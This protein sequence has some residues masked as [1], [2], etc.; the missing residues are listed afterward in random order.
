MISMNDTITKPM[1]YGRLAEVLESLGFVRRDTS[2]FTAFYKAE[3]D[4]IIGLPVLSPDEK[5]R[6]HHLLGI[7]ADIVGKRIATAKRFAQLLTREPATAHANGTNGNG[8]H[9]AANGIT[10]PRKVV[11]I[12]NG[13]RVGK[14]H[15]VLT[16][17]AKRG[18][19]D[20]D[21]N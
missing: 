7:Q 6:S 14:K 19:T 3:C 18:Q 4:A 16:A 21:A 8:T 20:N 10:R 15:A 12:E 17:S 2:E 11:I 1:T 13:K 9:A 5:I